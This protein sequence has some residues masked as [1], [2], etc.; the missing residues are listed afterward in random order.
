MAHLIIQLGPCCT[1]PRRLIGDAEFL[2][3]RV[4]PAGVSARQWMNMT[5]F[6]PERQGRRNSR[7]LPA[8]LRTS[9]ER[10]SP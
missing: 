9:R 2:A 8:P 4:P 3:P 1:V 10:P 7:D 5:T 6:L